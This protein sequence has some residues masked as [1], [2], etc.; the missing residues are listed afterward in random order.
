MSVPARLPRCLRIVYS[1]GDVLLTE[2]SAR[3]RLSDVLGTN[4]VI[5][6]RGNVRVL[7]HQTGPHAQG[8]GRR[9]R[10]HAVPIVNADKGSCACAAVAMPLFGAAL[11]SK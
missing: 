11:T 2:S 4:L 3:E 5:L 7:L 10:V 9:Y 1:H 6:G 8:K